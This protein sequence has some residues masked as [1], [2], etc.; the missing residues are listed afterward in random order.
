MSKVLVIAEAGVNHNG[1]LAIAKEMIEVAHEAGANF[2]KFQTFQAHKLVTKDALKA[3]YQIENDSPIENQ[4]DMLRALEL[5]PDDHFELINHC[6]Q[7][8][9][10]FLSTAFDLESLEFLNSNEINLI[11]VPSGEITNLPYLRRIGQLGREVVLSTG[12]ST[13]DE[14]GRALQAIESQGLKRE[15]ITVLHCT[16]AYPT[17]FPDVNLKA[18]ISIRDQY[19][20]KVGYSDHTLG[21]E[22]AIAAVALGATVLEKHFT[23]D[24]S[25]IGP[26]HKASL[27]PHELGGMIKAIRNIELALGEA[28][29][30]CQPSELP[31]LLAIRKSIVAATA[32]R[33]GDFFSEQN[34]T[35]K[36]PGGGISPMR[37]DEIVGQRSERDYETDDPIEQ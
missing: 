5:T 22:V 26:D 20:V 24:R 34:I 3:N 2:V 27:I 28:V 17:P 21:V 10:G 23:L 37:W 14:I 13:L 12:M 7:T 33:K 35:S 9:I 31:N 19:N 29:K 16:S 8:G 1:D 36:R 25:L 18:M 6:K 4:F 11:K 30:Q 15:K 32:I